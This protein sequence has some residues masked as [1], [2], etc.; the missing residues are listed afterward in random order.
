MSLDHRTMIGLAAGVTF[1]GVLTIGFIGVC[2]WAA[3]RR[4][5]VRAL[6]AEAA[7]ADR[8]MVDLEAADT[9]ASSAPLSKGSSTTSSVGAAQEPFFTAPAAAPSPQGTATTSD[10][11]RP[12]HGQDEQVSKS[13]TKV[14]ETSRPSKDQVDSGC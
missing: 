6:K 7:D 12:E 1:V 9:V 8:R 2:I 5:K 13:S 3:R 4:S 10:T 14:H 11:T